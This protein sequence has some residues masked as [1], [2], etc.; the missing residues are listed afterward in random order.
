[1]GDR[2]NFGSKIGVV[3]AAAGSAVGLGN[4]WRFPYELGQ[5]GGAAFLILYLL[6]VLIL[7]MPIMLSEFL[8][9]RMGQANSAGSF[10]KLAPGTK[11]A[12]VGVMGVI[13]SFLIM[14]FYV[15]VA[16]WTLEYV[17][18]A[19]SNQFANSDTATLSAAFTSFSSDTARPLIW[20]TVFMFLTAA[21]VYAGVK[22]GIEKST[23]FLMPVL[24]VLIIALGVRSVTLPGGMEGLRFLFQPDFSR[25]NSSVIL[26]AMGQAFFSL[27]LGMGCMI[28]YGSYI[29]K[30]NHLSHTVVEVSILDTIIAVL[31]SIAIFPAVFSLGINPAQGPELVFIT[32]PNVFSQMPGGYFWS[33]LFFVLLSVAALTSTISLLEVIVAYFVE[34]FS[35][36]RHTVIVF[37]SIGILLL[38][39][40]ASLSLGI[41]KD[42]QILGMGFFDLFDTLTSKVLMPIGGLFISIFVGWKLNKQSILNELSLHAKYKTS[43]FKLY[44][45]LIRYIAP[46]G[47]SLI[48]LNQLGLASWLGI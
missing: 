12:W 1:M 2:I 48:I 32:L 30:K 40:L 36:K 47:I 44:L 4:I 27:S 15:V 38:G 24:L 17:V 37:A 35:V 29:S 8:V 18:Q 16:G 13:A 10:R 31:A 34:E 28:T 20:M 14:G 25:I 3:A 41:F 46:V 19:V 21:I 33:I 26:S 7:G 45:F 9:G 5:Y 43:Y 11:W 39:T 6:F 23:K 42:V 22:N